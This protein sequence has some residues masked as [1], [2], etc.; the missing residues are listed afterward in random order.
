METVDCSDRDKGVLRCISSDEFLIDH[1]KTG[2]NVRYEKAPEAMEFW[3]EGLTVGNS[4][5]V[6]TGLSMRAD[7]AKDTRLILAKCSTMPVWDTTQRFWT[8]QEEWLSE[9]YAGFKNKGPFIVVLP[10]DKHKKK[11]A[12]ILEMV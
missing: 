3:L 10:K 1:K 9:Y 8:Y 2:N 4:T 12:N 7:I 5:Q 11:L 6:E